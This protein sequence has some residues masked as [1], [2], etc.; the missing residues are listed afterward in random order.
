MRSKLFVPGSRPALFDKAMAGAADALSFDLED[1]VV[2]A[3]KDMARAAVAEWL[4]RQ[5]ARPA[6]TL[7]VRINAMDTPWWQDD[8]RAVM[9]PA[10][11][12]VNLP[13]A[14]SVEQ[15]AAFGSAL[16][17]AERAAGI[18]SCP[19]ILLNIESA[20]AL[21]LAADLAQA[22]PRVRGLQLGLG[23][24]FEPLGIARRETAA[25]S[26]VML[27]LAL[28]AGEAGIAAYDG[29]FADIADTAGYTEEAALARRLGLAGKS[30]IHPSQ[31]E[32]ANAAF[33]PSDAEIAH[34]ERVLAALP[35]AETAGAGAFVVDGKM[36]DAPFIRRAEQI[37][38]LARR[39]GLRPQ[40]AA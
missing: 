30:C 20:R 28:A 13:K 22:H 14:E 17:A 34:A 33:R 31:V 3:S 38:A 37:M 21:R 24:L 40:E 4:A 19:G 7:I 25:L 35:A 26:I 8:L 39:L 9:Q 36:I 16:E 27:Q 29:A 1:A 2:P 6:K 15:V 10:L 12:I 18:T 11:G 5:P 32:L 23:D